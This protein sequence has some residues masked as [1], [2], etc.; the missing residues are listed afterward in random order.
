MDDRSCRRGTLAMSR[1]SIMMAPDV[2]GVIRRSAATRVDFPAPGC[3]H[4]R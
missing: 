2:N 1:P 3:S 4:V